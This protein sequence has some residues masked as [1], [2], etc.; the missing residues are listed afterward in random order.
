M[1]SK[2]ALLLVHA[3]TPNFALGENFEPRTFKLGL[4]QFHNEKPNCKF[5]I[6]LIAL[7]CMLVVG[8]VGARG[9]LLHVYSMTLRFS[10]VLL[11]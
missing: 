6:S 5:V 3:R 9:A 2:V 11:S 4:E 1:I 10:I 8:V 7:S